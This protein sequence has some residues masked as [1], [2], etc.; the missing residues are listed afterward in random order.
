MLPLSRR[1]RGYLKSWF[2]FFFKFTWNFGRSGTQGC[3]P[4]AARSRRRAQSPRRPGPSQPGSWHHR[5][6]IMVRSWCHQHGPSL[7]KHLVAA[8]PVLPPQCVGARVRHLGKET[9]LISFDFHKQ[10]LLFF[11]IEVQTSTLMWP[12]QS[13]H[14]VSL[15]FSLSAKWPAMYGYLSCL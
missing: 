13:F 5:D 2:E 11:D 3:R 15:Y 9:T 8:V 6:M 1:L 4:W 10:G 7:Y 12:R 14:V